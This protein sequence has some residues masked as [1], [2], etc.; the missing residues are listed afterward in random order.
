MRIGTSRVYFIGDLPVVV[1]AQGTRCLMWNVLMLAAFVAFV[2]LTPDHAKAGIW[3]SIFLALVAVNV[4]LS[5]RTVFADPGLV[6]PV[7]RDQVDDI[8]GIQRPNP[9]AEKRDPTYLDD[10]FSLFYCR[11]C[12]HLRPRETT[13]CK[14]TDACVRKF[15]HYCTVLGTVVGERNVGSFVVYLFSVS[16]SA[17]YG[18][19]LLVVALRGELSTLTLSNPR[20][21]AYGALFLCG[22]V[23]TVAVGFFAAYYLHL[24]LRGKSSKQFLTGSTADS[25]FGFVAVLKS[26]FVPAP[27]WLPEYRDSL[28]SAAQPTMV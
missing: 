10:L 8:D 20:L 16:V 3:Y 24:V 12:K 15:D 5:L 22:G 26:L 11:T 6:P 23:T 17:A 9:I 7:L 21:Y 27:S 4:A 2:Y 25:S 19:A 14:M 18:T 1:P 13:H 28:S